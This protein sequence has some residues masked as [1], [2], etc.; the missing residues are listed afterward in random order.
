MICVV[1]DIDGDIDK[2]M[3]KSRHLTRDDYVIIAGD[4]GFFADTRD[5]L[6]KQSFPFTLLFID[7][8]H[9]DFSLLKRY[10]MTEYCGGKVHKIANNVYHLLR[11]QVFELKTGEK[12]VK[13]AVLG[14]GESRDKEHRQ[15]NV[16][17]FAEEAITDEDL[18]ELNKN[19]KKHD[20]Q[21]DYFISHVPSAELKIL[22]Y[23]STYHAY[24]EKNGGI[25]S[26]LERKR[27]E[28]LRY[29]DSE[30]RVYTAIEG[31]NCPPL[32]A[33]A[34]YCGHEHHFCGE[35]Q[36]KDKKYH[37]LCQELQILQ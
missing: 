30:Y 9:E 14:G 4:V 28:R 24:L 37:I 12:N 21:V 11:G 18:A 23:N 5:K 25:F 3:E 7:G 33:K 2:L 15:E 22:L 20:Y 35:Y 1:S 13:I 10:D 8:N 26:D 34:Y 16:D 29:S 19:L 31:E 36:I 32:Q 6:L 27:L 17:W